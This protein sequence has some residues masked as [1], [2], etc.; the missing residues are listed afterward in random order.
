MPLPPMRRKYDIEIAKKLGFNMVRKHVKVEPA[1]W[2]YLRP[3]GHAGVAGHAQWQPAAEQ[4]RQPD[5]RPPSTRC[6]A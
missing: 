3:A 5:S 6:E 4:T 2:Y 1:R